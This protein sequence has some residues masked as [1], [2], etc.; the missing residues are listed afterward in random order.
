MRIF[1]CERHNIKSLPVLTP[2]GIVGLGCQGDVPTTELSAMLG[3]LP[4]P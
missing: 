2:A 3:L 4:K 1:L